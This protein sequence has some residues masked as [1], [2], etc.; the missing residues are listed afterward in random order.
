[1]GATDVCP[2]I[3]VANISMEETAKYALRPGK[4]GRRRIRKYR[5][6][7]MNQLS[8]TKAAAIFQSSGQEN[9]KGF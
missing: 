2:L 4:E 3:P 7:S 6:I 1:M 9:M 8:L 5:S